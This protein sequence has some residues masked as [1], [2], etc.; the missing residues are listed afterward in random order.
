MRVAV[1]AGVLAAVGVS[2]APANPGAGG[3][4]SGTS[5]TTPPAPS[6]R[7]AP[8]TPAGADAARSETE[9]G[10]APT[11]TSTGSGTLAGTS[12]RAAELAGAA[13]PA[14]SI[15]TITFDSPEHVAGS[16]GCNRFSG[17][18]A[19]EGQSLR[20]GPLLTTRRGCAPPLMEQEKSFLG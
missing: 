15:P 2:C 6:A 7:A 20:F 13:A 5:G 11:H 16:T 10:T 18:A 17:K 4:G 14:P 8:S 12:W 3:A 9:H 19:I 1:F